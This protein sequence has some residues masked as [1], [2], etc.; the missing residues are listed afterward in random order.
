MTQYVTDFYSRTVVCTND[1]EVV[2]SRVDDLIKHSLD[3]D[4]KFSDPDFG[5]N[6]KDPK[7]ENAIFYPKDE[8]V[9][10]QGDASVGQY[11]NV[12]G[13]NIDMIK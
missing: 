7:G 2:K 4:K 8:A 10:I 11:N 1:I 3:A 12:A 5:P 13:L 9:E 6:P